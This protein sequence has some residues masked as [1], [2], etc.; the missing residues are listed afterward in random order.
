[1]SETKNYIHIR[2]NRTNEI[3]V[4]PNDQEVEPD[5]FMWSEGNFS[6]D[7]NRHDF[8]EG[9]ET[10]APCGEGEYSVNIKGLNG[11][12]IYQEYLDGDCGMCSM[13]VE[14]G[15]K[16]VHGHY[17]NGEPMYSNFCKECV[18]KHHERI[19]K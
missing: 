7:C 4:I 14:K 13:P 16:H 6:C 9:G 15:L 17:E 12:V 2:K 1:M 8:F 10:N 5:D 18:K 3:K 19:S 11:G